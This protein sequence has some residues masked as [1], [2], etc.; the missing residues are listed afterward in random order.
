MTDVG[1]VLPDEV[2]G[3]PSGLGIAVADPAV[4]GVW[5]GVGA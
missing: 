3:C 2:D 5:Q 1:C 4:P